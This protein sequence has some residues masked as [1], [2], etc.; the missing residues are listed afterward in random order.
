MVIAEVVWVLSAKYR[1]PKEK[2]VDGIRRLLNTRNI[3]VEERALLL[4]AV[5]LFEQYPMDFIDAYN[6]ATMQAR[7]LDTIYSY[8]TDFDALQGIR[9][10]EP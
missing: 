1:H 8:D 9:R 3:L 5:Q 7:G 4:L 6:G 2:V 10:L